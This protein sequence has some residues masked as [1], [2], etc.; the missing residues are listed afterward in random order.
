[1][2]SNTLL[3][4]GLGILLAL[5]AAGGAAAQT[6]TRWDIRLT[7]IAARSLTSWSGIGGA[8]AGLSLEYRLSRRLGLEVG[9][10]TAEV[11]GEVGFDFF[12]F[13]V[14]T[15]ESAVRTNQ[16]LARLDVHL[17][18]GYRVD[19]YLGPVAGRMRYGDLEVKI[20]SDVVGESV[21]LARVGTKDG[22]A[23]GGHIGMDVLIGDRGLFFTSGVTL[24]RAKVELD[25]ALDEDI[26][27]DSFELNPLMVQIGFGY[28]F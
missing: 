12:G 8:G 1:M 21:T 4:A 15:I 20:E 26:G 28:R 16:V 25:E 14:L 27:G 6:D 18:P 17:T 24:L 10:L 5:A 2:K 3:A 13:D 19:L 11:E 9:V 22:S 23:W 7:G